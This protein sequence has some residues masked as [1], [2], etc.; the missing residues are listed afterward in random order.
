MDYKKLLRECD[1]LHRENK[2]LRGEIAK[3]LCDN[4]TLCWLHRALWFM[5]GV[6]SALIIFAGI[7]A[8]T[9][10]ASTEDDLI[11]ALER[12]RNAAR[13]EAIKKYFK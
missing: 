11:R 9:D 13:S 10:S 7:C 4:A 12:Y 6:L 1:I 3:A 5:I 2:Y 8:V